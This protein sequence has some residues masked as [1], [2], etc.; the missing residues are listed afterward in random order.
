MART[1]QE[2][3]NLLS[4][5]VEKVINKSH[6]EKSLLSGKKLRVKHGIDPTGEKIHLGRA[7]SL[8]KLREFQN[9]GHKIVLIIGDFTAQIGDPSDKLLKR[10]FL[11]KAQVERNLKNYLPQ[12]GKIINLKKTEVRYNS[13][14]LG[15]LKFRE[16]SELADIFSVQQMIRRRNFNERWKKNQEISLRELTYPLMQGYDSVAVKADVEI[17]GSDQLFNLLAGRKIQEH[18]DQKPQ[19]ILT[20]MMLLGLDS[21]KMST[22]WGNVINVSDPPDEQYGKIMSMHDNQIVNYFGLVT[23]VEEK[24][25]AAYAKELKSKKTNPKFIKEKLAFE[26]VKK[27]HGAE[28][29]N[30]A[31]KKFEALFSKKGTIKGLRDFKV[32]RRISAVDFVFRS[33]VVKSK[34]EARRLVEQGGFDVD[35]VAKKKPQE[36][37]NLRGGEVLKI[38]KKSFFRVKV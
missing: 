6:L 33:G 5:N 25:I 38:G 13:E 35:G 22:S 36:I 17:G 34:S 30:K 16:I 15:K 14:W 24:V 12:I 32:L 28:A 19:D 3:K 20:T 21:R 23:D 27:Y 1:A 8:W 29:A 7:V 18:Y 11:T 2:V 31:A 37:L 9:L 26:I 10:P 4:R